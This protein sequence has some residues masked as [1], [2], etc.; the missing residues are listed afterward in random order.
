MKIVHATNCYLRPNGVTVA[1]NKYHH[2]LKEMGIES[3]VLAPD[4]QDGDDDSII[5][6]GGKIEV[7]GYSTFVNFGDLEESSF[8][9]IK[10]AEIIHLHHPPFGFPFILNPLAREAFKFAKQNGKKTVIHI[11]SR[12]DLDVNSY[13]AIARLLSRV[14]TGL[15]RYSIA[16]YSNQVDC[17]IAPSVSIK[18]LLEDWGVKTRIEVIPTSVD[19]EKFSGG[20]RSGIREEY[21]IKEKE[22]LVSYI[23]RIAEDKNV[24]A[25]KEIIEI[26]GIK[27][28]FVGDGQQRKALERVVGNSRH[29]NKV[30][31]TGQIPYDRVQD[32]YAASDIITT[33][34][35]SETQCLAV[36]EAHAAGKP[37]VAVRAPGIS[38]Y[39][40]DGVN[41][42]LAN[43]SAELKTYIGRLDEDRVRLEELSRGAI[44]VSKRRKR[45]P[46]SAERLAGVYQRLL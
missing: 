36:W 40:Q 6:V 31:F 42:V 25:L 29:K 13:S 26:D 23:G 38:D 39:V 8:N 32:Y 12:Y 9:E 28:M 16:R 41:G 37:V 45:E 22:L 11:H 17:V 10:S 5:R 2:D 27:M 34:C 4:K 43:R 1:I 15:V 3:L 35:I 46:S 33:A 14:S 19:V 24:L 30:I 18:G 20:N 7:N 44:E 21:Q